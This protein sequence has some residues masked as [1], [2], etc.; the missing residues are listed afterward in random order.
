M[1]TDIPNRF[2]ARGPISFLARYIGRR[3]ISHSV[4]LLSVVV[5]VCCSIGSQYAVRTLVDVLGRQSPT[6]L[7]IWGTVGLLLG[8]VAADNLLWRVAG[9][10]STKAFVDVGGDI[11]LDL[12]SYLSGQDTRYFQDRFPGA[13]AARITTAANVTW[14]IENS[15]TWMSIPPAAG[16][17]L[18]LP[19]WA[20]VPGESADAEADHD[21]AAVSRGGLGEDRNRQPNMKQNAIF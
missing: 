9:W 8:L 17:N 13:L 16:A 2:P 18:A 15:L 19:Q 3:A 4:V 21:A 12:F 10:T 6:S 14:T 5:A 1:A 20:Y 7:A 11:R